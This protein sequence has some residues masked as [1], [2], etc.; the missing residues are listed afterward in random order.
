MRH[1]VDTRA[2]LTEIGA[3]A[4]R[5]PSCSAT[6]E[7]GSLSFLTRDALGVL[8]VQGTHGICYGMGPCE[9]KEKNARYMQRDETM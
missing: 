9:G 1:G 8:A 7:N 3:S 2:S 5:I 4:S 6:N